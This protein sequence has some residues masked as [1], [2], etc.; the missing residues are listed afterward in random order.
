[1]A[2]SVAPAGFSA[3]WSLIVGKARSSCCAAVAQGEPER[4]RASSHGRGH[5][6]AQGRAPVHAGGVR[7]WLILRRGS[8]L[9]PV[10]PSVAG[11]FI[12]PFSALA[13][14]GKADSALA[15][16]AVSFT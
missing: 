1:M 7:W 15:S 4:H 8:A 6:H 2:M 12:F 11:H 10:G 9:V 16:N 5:A 14:P 3:R 13:S